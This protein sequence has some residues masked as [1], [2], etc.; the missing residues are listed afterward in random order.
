VYLYAPDG[1]STT[2][3]VSA[4]LKTAWPPVVATGSPTVGSGL[5]QSKLAANAQPDGTSIVSYNGHL[6]YTFSG[7]AAAGDAKGQGLGSVWYV[8]SAS[9]EMIG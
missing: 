1:A 8:L 2:S 9:G 6:L 3:T 4:G 5:D 7:D